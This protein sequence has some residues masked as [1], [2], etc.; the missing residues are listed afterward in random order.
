MTGSKKYVNTITMVSALALG[1]SYPIISTCEPTV[2][3]VKDIQRSKIDA[4]LKRDFSS[5][6][7]HVITKHTTNPVEKFKSAISKE[8]LFC[9]SPSR[10]KMFPIPS[11]Y[12]QPYLPTLIYLGEIRAFIVNGVI[13]NIFGTTPL[14]GDTT[15][16]EVE[17]AILLRPL[18]QM[19]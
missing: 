15:N 8:K 16:L 14:E 3:M 11:W 10:P 17:P 4:A 19:R 7:C 6:S 13:I 9:H 1:R 18:S 2:K 12:L 5:D